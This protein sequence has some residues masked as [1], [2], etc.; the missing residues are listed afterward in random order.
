MIPSGISPVSFTN[1]IFLIY[2]AAPILV[3]VAVIKSFLFGR[4]EK[5]PVI[6]EEAENTV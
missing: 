3:A 2:P 4:R 5:K 6:D 1:F